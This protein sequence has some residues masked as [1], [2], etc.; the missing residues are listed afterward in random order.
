MAFGFAR[1]LIAFG[2]SIAL[3]GCAA[4]SPPPDLPPYAVAPGA[5]VGLLLSISPVVAHE[6]VGTTVFNNFSAEQHF[7]RSLPDLVHADFTQALQHANYEVVE[8]DPAI[9]KAPSIAGLLVR[10]NE[11]WTVAQEHVKQFAALREELHLSAIIVA[12]SA[13]TLVQRECTQYGC[14][15]RIA[16]HSGL[17]TRSFLF[18]NRWFAVPGFDTVV[19]NVGPPIVL[20]EYEP[21]ASIAGHKVKELQDMKAP[22][23]FNSL[24]DDE[25][26]PVSTWVAEYVQQMANACVMALA[27]KAGKAR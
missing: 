14:T 24:T 25:F 7:P 26:A 17:F 13:P 22:K 18:A 19:L 27:G 21:M 6:H 15:D 10:E 1:G 23:D 11:Q 20:S 5:R 2:I 8:L 3:I 12:Y 16:T 9:Y 4:L